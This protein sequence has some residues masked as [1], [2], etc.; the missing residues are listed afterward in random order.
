VKNRIGLAVLQL[1]DLNLHVNGEQTL[2][3]DLT[4]HIG[5]TS[6]D[7]ARDHT[8]SVALGALNTSTADGDV[9]ID[10]TFRDWHVLRRWLLTELAD[11]ATSPLA[12]PPAANDGVVDTSQ[13][14]QGRIALGLGEFG[15]RLDQRGELKRL[16]AVLAS[17]HV[18]N[19][20][21]QPLSSTNN[22]NNNNKDDDNNNDDDE[23]SQA[24][25]ELVRRLFSSSIP[26]RL[27]F[28]TKTHVNKR[29]NL[30]AIERLQKELRD[31]KQRLESMQLE[32]NMLD[33]RLNEL[34][35]ANR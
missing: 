29:D 19:T 4:S 1:T 27:V 5:L 25:D 3:I 32:R 20:L 12:P 23:K 21:S 15:A 9:S 8:E 28:E 7:T 26:L 10:A 13:L 35:E 34:I 16:R 17:H 31:A 18:P 11:D 14:C 22:N 24:T 2:A 33:A 30:S 6:L